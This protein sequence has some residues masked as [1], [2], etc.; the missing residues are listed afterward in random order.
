MMMSKY[1]TDKKLREIV[2]DFDNMDLDLDNMD[3]QEEHIFSDEHN[4]KMEAL[5][6]AWE[7]EEKGAE[8]SKIIRFKKNNRM[9]KMV[10]SILIV[11]LIGVSVFHTDT[12]L[13]Y[14][15]KIKNF[16]IQEFEKYSL[17]KV[18]D[19]SI[20]KDSDD[21]F[22]DFTLEYESDDFKLD[23]QNKLKSYQLYEYKNSY[24]NYFYIK[25][26]KSKDDLDIFVDTENIS[27]KSKLVDDVE[28]KYIENNG[29]IRIYYFKNGLVFDI[30]TDI[31]LESAFTEIK[32]IK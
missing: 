27:I 6:K 3:L 8:K 7:K 24:G 4:R 31:P 29:V 18:D 13:A 10:A 20:G 15:N 5:F 14:A 12:V 28:Y 21:E 19:K 30:K 22:V 25:V 16:V 11:L 1:I 26:L 9:Y 2:Y 17:F 23:Y 32:K